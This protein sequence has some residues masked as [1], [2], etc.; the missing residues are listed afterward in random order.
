[1]DDF[2]SLYADIFNYGIYNNTKSGLADLF[3]INYYTPKSEENIIKKLRERNSENDRILLKWI[4]SDN[5]HN[6]FYILGV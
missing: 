3:G 5:E 2:L 6:G 1:M 4:E